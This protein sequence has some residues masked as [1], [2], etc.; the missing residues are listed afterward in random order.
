MAQHQVDADEAEKMKASGDYKTG[1]EKVTP[2]DDDKKVEEGDESWLSDEDP[3]G[4]ADKSKSDD[5]KSDDDK[6][7]DDDKSEDDKVKED[8]VEKFGEQSTK[9][10]EEFMEKGELSTETR[11]EIGKAVFAPGVPQEQKDAYIDSY[12]QNASAAG[13]LANLAA[14]EIVG[15]A[16]NYANMVK[17]G[18]KNLTEAQIEAFDGDITG[19]DTSRRDTAIQGLYARMQQDAGFEPDNEQS[20]AHDGGR[21]KGEPIIGSRQELAK[22]QGTE[23]YKKDPAY[24][25]LVERQLRQSMATGQYRSD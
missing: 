13:Q 4:D 6:S 16:E 25:D 3:D 19:S 2:T 20:L 23:R 12:V 5:D 9:W 11:E 10:T 18:Q 24:Q 22:I 15:G 17:W 21:G 14:Y 8:L 1:E 7:D